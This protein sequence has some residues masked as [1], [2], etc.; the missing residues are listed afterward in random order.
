MS[1]FKKPGDPAGITFMI[2]GEPGSGKTWFGL[3]L[4]RVTG[5]PVAYIGLDRGAKFYKDHPEVGGFLAVESRDADTIESAIKELVEDDGRS[6]GAVVLDTVTDLWN[7]EQKKYEKKGKD[8]N[9]FIPMRA[10][11]P[12]REGHEQKLR[13]IQALPIHVVLICEE[14][15]IYEK[16][17]SGE[18]VEL[19][20]VGSKEDADKKD[21]YIC[22]VRLRFYIIDGVRY[23][24]VLK[25]RT[26]TYAAG[27]V[28][29]EPRPEMWVKGKAA[30]AAKPAQ[31]AAPV[32]GEVAKDKPAEPR[33]VADPADPKTIANGMV[34]RI[35]RIA[36]K[37][38]AKNW[39]KK[40]REEIAAL[41][42]LDAEQHER[43]IA[44]M[45]EKAEE[46]GLS[47]EGAAGG[48]A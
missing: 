23:A 8:G 17:G 34:E 18:Q 48:A 20:E 36:N 30:R 43:V 21:A 35:A 26:G 28:V 46:L 2:R 15:A 29:K 25:D 37:F 22:D 44:A 19:V 13:D 16:R 4:K 31:M 38:E 27:D 7:A 47:G 40:H 10:W 1:L 33:N 3:G 6:Y 5:L 24:E 11:R 9:V 39:S 32:D 45:Q 12:L 42:E 41:K 14:K